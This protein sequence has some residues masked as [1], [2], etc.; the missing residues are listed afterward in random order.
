MSLSDRFERH[1]QNLLEHELFAEHLTEVLHYL[2]VSTEPTTFTPVFNTSV[3]TGFVMLMLSPL[4]DYHEALV[5]QLF[6]LPAQLEQMFKEIVIKIND[7]SSRLDRSADSLGF[8]FP[9]RR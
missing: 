6:Y 5:P 8:T 2:G 3:E 7:R 1:H 9:C 4:E